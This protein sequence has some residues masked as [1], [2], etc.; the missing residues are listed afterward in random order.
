MKQRIFRGSFY[1][2]GMV[3]LALGI[4]LNTKTG[5]GVS[6]IISLPTSVSYLQGWN[7]GN[8]TLILYVIMVLLQK[9]MLGRQFPLRSWLQLPVTLV[10]S[11]VINLFND[12]IQ[13]PT[14]N[15][16]VQLALLALAILLIAVGMTFSLYMDLV[17]NPGDGIV[18][19]LCQCSGWNL[20][21]S[22]NVVDLTCVAST[23]IYTLLAS[24]R[25]QYIGIG[26]LLTML[27]VGRVV[28]LLG[29][30]LRKPLRRLAGLEP[31]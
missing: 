10:F 6:P 9:G 27:L 13:V 4:T 31:G 1:T 19:A 25:V 7:L 5:L 2:F 16:P 26:T 20:G 18:Y 29:R 24:G 28:A 23:C 15:L 22:K 30:F 17:P 21:L 14:D 8:M 12:G 11:R 3:V